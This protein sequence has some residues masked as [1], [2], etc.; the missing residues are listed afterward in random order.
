MSVAQ[1]RSSPALLTYGS[2]V[3]LG[4]GIGF[5]LTLAGVVGLIVAIGITAD[6]FIVYFERIRDEIR[7]GRTLRVGRRD[8]AGSAPGAR[9]SS[10][11]S[12]RSSPPWCSTSSSVGSVRGFAFTLGLTTLIDVVVVFLF[13]KPLVTLLARTQVLRPGAPAGPGSTRERLGGAAAAAGAGAPPAPG[14]AP[15]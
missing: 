11:T 5:A 13:T 4:V 9:S 10:P 14:R 2:V 3:L 6:S 8:A 1:P 7:E 15:P 12:C